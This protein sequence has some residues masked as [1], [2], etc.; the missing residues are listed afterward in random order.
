MKTY[1]NSQHIFFGSRVTPQTIGNC[2]GIP[3]IPHSTL[4]PHRRVSSLSSSKQVRARFQA[5]KARLESSIMPDKLRVFTARQD[6]SSSAGQGRMFPLR[7]S[8]PDCEISSVHRG[9]KA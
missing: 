9:Y 7:Q 1:N 5:F 4:Y 8:K 6:A 3:T 2:L